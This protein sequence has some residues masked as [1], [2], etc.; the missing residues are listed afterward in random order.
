M[1][2]LVLA[3][4]SPRRVDLLSRLGWPF[5][6]QVSGVGEEVEDESDPAAMVI[7]LAERKARA[8]AGQLHAGLVIGAD[9]TVVSD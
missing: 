4:G 5:A 1:S 2:D 9:T 3:S 7:H 6:V 8:V